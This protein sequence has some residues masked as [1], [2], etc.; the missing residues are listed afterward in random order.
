MVVSTHMHIGD[1]QSV[2]DRDSIILIYAFSLR[3]NDSRIS[4]DG[5]NGCTARLIRPH[6]RTDKSVLQLFEASISRCVTPNNKDSAP[7]NRPQHPH[8]VR[9]HKLIDYHRHRTLTDVEVKNLLNTPDRQSTRKG[10][11][12]TVLVSGVH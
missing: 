5:V 3:V 6:A 10:M 12:S 4:V 7:I 2:T 11:I 8:L 1:F 9:K